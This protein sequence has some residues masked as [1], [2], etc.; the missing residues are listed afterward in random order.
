M[1]RNLIFIVAI[2]IVVWLVSR[3]IK[4]KSQQISSKT[5]Q[6]KNNEIKNIVQCQICQAF[7][8]EDKAIIE[9]NHTFCSQQHLEQWKEQQ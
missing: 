2:G 1:F 5:R 4:S 7:V 9:N 8:P 6:V 3:M